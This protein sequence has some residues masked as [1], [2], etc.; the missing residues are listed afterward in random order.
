[1]MSIKHLYNNTGA[2]HIN[3]HSLYKIKERSIYSNLV[4]QRRNRFRQR[5]KRPRSNACIFTIDI[6]GSLLPTT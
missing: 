1:M 6:A 4:R 3:K 5:F 2:I